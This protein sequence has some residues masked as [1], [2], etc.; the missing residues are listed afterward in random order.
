MAFPI[1]RMHRLRQNEQLRHLVRRNLL[2]LDDF[3]M[4]L[5]VRPG[6]G[7]RRPI[8]PMPGQVQFSPDTIADE[9]REIQSQGVPAVLLVGVSERRDAEGSAAWAEDGVVQVAVRNIK[10]KCKNLA[11]ISDVCLC[12]YTTQAHC[13]LVRE[14]QGRQ[15]ID[16]DATL[17]VLARIAVSHARAGADI[18]SPSDMM[19]GRIA[20]IR[21]ALDDAGFSHV[22]I[23][24]VAAS[25]ASAFHAP[26]REA[27][28]SEPKLFDRKGYQI[29]YRN[30]KDPMRE[31][32]FD[33]EEG[34]DIVMIKPAM[35]YLDIIYRAK[36]RFDVPIACF[37]ASGE[38]AMFKAAAQNGW[39][40]EREA[41]IEA[42]VG[43][44]RSGADLIVS[45]F[46]KDAAEWLREMAVI[47][48]TD[49]AEPPAAGD[50]GK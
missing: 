12:E 6:K 48:P 11:V 17:E 36:D 13:G 38:Y 50:G 34:A 41:V 10:A 39:L 29:D 33:I 47:R 2:S 18:V 20:R 19:D 21:A 30:E 8:G 23:M 3:V 43:M 37:N 40:N 35:A 5:F 42:L 25:F 27:A 31:I 14:R 22:A 7:I 24:S 4:P 32:A 1:H 44:K 15:T 9:C 16:N 45:F 49:A 26:M 28:E 46:A